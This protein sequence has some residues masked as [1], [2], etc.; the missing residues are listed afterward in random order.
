MATLP[1][2]DDGVRRSI[3]IPGRT[4]KS[5]FQNNKCMDKLNQLRFAVDQLIGQGNLA[6]VDSVFLEDYIA[7]SGD[8]THNGHKFIKQF[9][10]QIRTAIPDI[11]VVNV[12]FLSHSDN[13]VTWQ[14]TFRGTHKSDMKGIPASNK[15]VRWYEIVVSR[16]DKDKIVEEWVVS[17]LGF[18]LML[19]HK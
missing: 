16:F 18:Q 4:P 12:E 2:A 1:A 5:M 6:M 17:D 9:I 10:K 3:H 15:K 11:K 19:K 7:H 8:K 13:M 14:R